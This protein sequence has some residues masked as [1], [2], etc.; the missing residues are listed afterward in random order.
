LYPPE[1]LELYHC[2]V[3][4]D[5]PSDSVRFHRRLIRDIRE[6]GDTE[7]KVT[8]AW[9]ENVLPT[10]YRLIQPQMAWADVVMLGDGDVAIETVNYFV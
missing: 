10:H 9:I 5:V 4:V 8:K 7:V 2:K 3:F 6:R 1:L